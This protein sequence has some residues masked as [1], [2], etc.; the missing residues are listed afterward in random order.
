M[1]QPRV[2]PERAGAVA[3]VEDLDDRLAAAGHQV[4]VRLWDG[5]T[6]GPAE[7]SWRLVLRHPWSLRTLL[8]PLSDL[9]AGEAYLDDDVDVE[10]SMVAAMRA[11]AA[12]RADGLDAPGRLGVMRS[13]LRLPAP[14]AGRRQR[15]QHVVGRGRTRGRAHTLRRDAQ[16]VRHHYDV[17]NDFYRLFLD[18]ALV[19]S[20]AC[21]AEEDR[22]R[23]VTDREVLARAQ[24]RKLELIC[25]KL[26]LRPDERLLDVGCGWGALVIHAARRHGVR[27]LGVTLS[28]EQAELARQR[29]EQAGLAD[30]VQIEVRDYREVDGQFDAIASV[31]MVEHVGA[32]QLSRYARHLAR[33]LVPGGRLLNHGITT[34]GRDVVRDFARDTDGFVARHVFPDGALVPAHRTVTEIERAG[35]ELW[36]VQQL[37]PH[38]ARTLEHWVA[39]LEARADDAR[40]LVGERVYRTWRAYMAGSVVGFERNDLG[41]VQVL[42][43]RPPTGLP[44]GRG[45][46]EPPP[47][48]S[49]LSGSW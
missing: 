19:Y 28:P 30:R 18:P 49:D 17:G 43:V 25:R 38:Y 20:C 40:A 23:P 8:V 34:G 1:R 21:F 9:A 15:H 41:L 13:L 39:N 33:L 4:P 2:R 16:V 47:P 12:L 11:V 48:A 7:A 36:D 10:G 31:G 44:W 14:P 42:A 5:R 24:W 45:W 27:A 35:L 46:M 3:V 32:G 6:L 29:V 37:R 22:E 26:A